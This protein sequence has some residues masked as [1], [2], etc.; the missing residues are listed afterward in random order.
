MGDEGNGAVAPLGP[1]NREGCAMEIVR[2]IVDLDGN[3][4]TRDMLNVRVSSREEAEEYIR[5]HVAKV[6]SLHGYNEE[7]GYWWGR[8]DDDNQVSRFTVEL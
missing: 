2:R 7:Y 1:T 6:F 5:S 4:I 3:L 8:Q